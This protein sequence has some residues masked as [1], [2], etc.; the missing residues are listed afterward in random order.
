MKALHASLLLLAGLAF[1]SAAVAAPA[2]GPAGKTPAAAA[3]PAPRGYEAYR[4]VRTVNIFDPDRR[5]IPKPEDVASASAAAF[6]S[7]TRSSRI[8]LTGTMVE[9]NKAYA[10]FTGTRAEYNKVIPVNAKIADCTVKAIEATHVDLEENGKTIVLAVGNQLAL[11]GSGRVSG[12]PLE[13]PT[14][15]QM[16]TGDTASASSSAPAGAA[17]AG[18]DASSG[19]APAAPAAP[20]SQS[21]ILKRMMEKAAQSRQ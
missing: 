7:N 1:G 4:L 10:F 18:G 8:V 17:P 9:D 2:A 20:S 6:S 15:Q 21:D 13:A 14:T 11:D 12:A 5:P 19:A 3:T 16:S